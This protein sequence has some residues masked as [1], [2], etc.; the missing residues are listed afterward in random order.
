M[1]ALKIN[2]T[3][4]LFRAVLFHIA[5]LLVFVEGRLGK[6]TQIILPDLVSYQLS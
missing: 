3:A 5:F 6:H 2:A 1:M 4:F